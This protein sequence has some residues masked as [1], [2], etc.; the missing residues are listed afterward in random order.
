[1]ILLNVKYKCTESFTK[2]DFYPFI[3][4]WVVNTKD[5]RYHMDLNEQEYDNY[6]T[7]EYQKKKLNFVDYS[8]AGILAAFHADTDLDGTEW[9]LSVVFKPELHEMYI[10]MSNS[11]TSESG[12]YLR[13]FK[14]PDLID[15]LVDLKIIRKDGDIKIQ[16]TSHDVEVENINEIETIIEG[17]AGNTLPVIL[18][19]TTPYGY[20]AADPEALADR[21]AGMAHVFTQRDEDVSYI[22]RDKYKNRAA[23]GGSIVT[24]FPVKSLQPNVIVYGRYDEKETNNRISKGINFY[25]KSQNYGQMTTYDEISSVVISGRNKN[26]ISQNEQIIEESQKIA[27]ENRSIVETFD[28][29]LK[30][31]DEENT[32]LKQRIADLEIENRIL[33]ERLNSIS[34]K[35]LLIYGNEEEVYPGEIKELLIDILENFNLK[36]GSRRADIVKDILCNNQI[37]SSL[38]ER[39]DELKDILNNYRGLDTD[40]INRLERLGF[41]VTSDGKH[42]KLTY[43][44]DRYITTLSK[45]SSDVRSGKNAISLI[46]KNMM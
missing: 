14:K 19:S 11:E 20:Y 29:D 36:D 2:E 34:E 6:Q 46:M 13:K 12:R 23:Y 16:Y 21:Y 40:Q 42:H 39:Y 25:Y 5:L 3:F 26:L 7:Y 1:M 37:N 31:T 35:P 45:T 9:K 38:K 4:D 24:Y 33:K 10:Q 28:T 44:D 32:R 22:L 17:T 15:E 41:T 43:H 8:D 27:D 18:L 30:K